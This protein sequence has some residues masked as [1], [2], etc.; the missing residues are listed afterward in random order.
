MHPL[1]APNDGRIKRANVKSRRWG[2]CSSK[3]NCESAPCVGYFAPFCT[4]GAELVASRKLRSRLAA[5]TLY[6]NAAWF[7]LSAGSIS[8]AAS[9]DLSAPTECPSPSKLCACERRA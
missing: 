8:S 7:F 5:A 4:A 6:L 9:A 3:H 2:S 1:K